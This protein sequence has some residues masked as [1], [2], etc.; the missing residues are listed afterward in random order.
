MSEANWVRLS[1]NLMEIYAKCSNF[2]TNV[3]GGHFLE[4]HKVF[5]EATY[6]YFL[7]STKSDMGGNV[8][9]DGDKNYSH[10]L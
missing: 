9:N 1:H 4:T 7:M 6:F 3:W 8:I 5:L 10:H 2:R